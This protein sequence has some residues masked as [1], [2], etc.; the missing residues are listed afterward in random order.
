MS[1]PGT[2]KH[3]L[4]IED[5]EGYRRLV[6]NMLEAADFRVTTAGD[7][8][9]AM[10]VIESEEPLDLLLAD[11]QLPT[12]TPHGLAIGLMTK[13]KRPGLATIYMTGSFDAEKFAELTQGAK[14]LAKPFTAAQ[15]VGTIYAALA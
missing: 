8:T 2:A 14:V 4:V 11:V 13:K 3:I 6:K 9:S 15:L 7:F 5:D 1:E 10:Q 12:K